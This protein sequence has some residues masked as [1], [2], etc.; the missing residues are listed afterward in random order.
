MPYEKFMRQAFVLAK[1]GVGRTSPNPVV[2][3]VMV[4]GGRVIAKG[5]HKKAGGPHAEIEALK[6]AGSRA[7][8]S[9]LFVT[10]EPCCH[11]G[12]TPP[13]TDA[14]IAAGI[15]KV[16]VGAFDPNPKVSGKGV[17]ALRA[18]GIEV[19]E[20]VLSS[21]CS[22]LN[23]A[24][25]KYIT[26][27]LP[28]VTLKLAASLDGRIATS[29]GDSKWITGIESR[30]LVHRMRALSDAVMIGAETALKDDPELTVRLASG[31]DPVRVVLDSS[32]RVPVS[33]KVFSGL[34]EGQGR[35]IIFA[36]ND[37]DE[38]RVKK[39][40]EAGAEVV[41]LA[42]GARGLPL[43]KVLISLANRGVTSVLVEGGGKLAASLLKEKLIDALTV[44][45]GPMIIGS[46]GLPMIAC[47]GLKGL[48]GAPRFKSIV[49][50]KA[51]DDIIIEARPN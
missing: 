34:K 22:A 45:Y 9:T 27:G 29:S 20:G 36:S 38:K 41:R 31:R 50:K 8:G 24:W 25:N 16:V 46:E 42:P 17:A 2:G 28:F 51:G 11:F 1:K 3:S 7:K 39:A 5:W 48:K 12:K 37:A 13:C 47:L 26:T 4:K 23:E 21:E 19:T 49:V 32:L 44:F 14:I 33:S 35:L 18:A 30:R 15:K 43:K 6:A 10:L 40:V